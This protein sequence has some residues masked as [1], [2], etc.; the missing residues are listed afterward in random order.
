[1][2]IYRHELKYRINA[3]DAAALLMRLRAVLSPDPNAPAGQYTVRSLYFDDP[4]STALAEKLYGVDQRYKYRLRIYNQSDKKILLERKERVDGVGTKLSI[5][6]TREEAD[7]FLA[8]DTSLLLKKNE[9]VATLFYSDFKSG[10]LRPRR[11]VEYDRTAFVHPSENVRITL[12]RRLRSATG[13]A[14]FF[15]AGTIA[16]PMSCDVLEVKYDRYLP[17]HISHLVHMDNHF[18]GPNSKYLNSSVYDG[19]A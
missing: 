3:M 10:L 12:D 17:S 16:V 19:L 15:T 1:M 14:D 6:F 5:P 11:I 8:G 18:I 2:S 7:R 4:Y 13:S 9:A